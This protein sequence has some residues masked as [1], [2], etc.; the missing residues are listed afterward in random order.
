MRSITTRIDRLASLASESGEKSDMLWEL[1]TRRAREL[2]AEQSGV[3]YLGDAG[4]VRR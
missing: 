3:F 2:G 1:Y 4:T